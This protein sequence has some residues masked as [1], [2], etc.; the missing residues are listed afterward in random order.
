MIGA[1]QRAYAQTP[2]PVGAAELVA[3]QGRLRIRCAELDATIQNFAVK[4][5]DRELSGGG[6][7]NRNGAKR[8][9]QDR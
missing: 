6:G 8:K 3:Y 1:R 5:L 7:A 2:C 4:L 9:E